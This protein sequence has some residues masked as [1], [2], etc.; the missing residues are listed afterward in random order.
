MYQLTIA[1]GP[2]SRVTC[3]ADYD[4]ARQ[5]L[6]DHAITADVYLHG[7]QALRQDAVSAPET[8]KVQLL[9]LDPTSGHP[10]CVGTATITTPAGADAAAALT[11]SMMGAAAS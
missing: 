10:Q 7:D 6:L 2:T 5:A 11:P 3:H 8:T 4:Q 1:T 9:Q